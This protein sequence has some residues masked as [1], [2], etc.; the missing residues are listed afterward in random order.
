MPKAYGMR[1]RFLRDDILQGIFF[2]RAFAGFDAAKQRKR[3]RKYV[4]IS[5][6]RFR[7][8]NEN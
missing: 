2:T 4:S 1:L 6:Y 8:F 3:F 7:R 5:K